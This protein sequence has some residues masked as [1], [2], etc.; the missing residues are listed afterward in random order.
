[1]QRSE[2]KDLA[3]KRKPG[4]EAHARGRDPS[5]RSSMTGYER[6]ADVPNACAPERPMAEHLNA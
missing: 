6:K 2:V 4:S 1:M 5:L 3:T